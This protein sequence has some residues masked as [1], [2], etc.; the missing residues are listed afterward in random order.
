MAQ[1]ARDPL[2][3][4]L[5]LAI[6]RAARCLV[7]RPSRDAWTRE[8]EAEIRHRWQAMSRRQETEW[9]QQATLVR[10]SSGA[11]ADAA[12][13]RQQ[14]TADLD[15]VRDARYA[16]RMLRARPLVSTFAVVVLAL[17]ICGT[18]TV[19]STVDTLLLRDLPY[20]DSNRIVTI[21]QTP[22]GNPD[23]REGV[24]P[25]AFVDWRARTTS[26]SALGSAE[27]WSFDYLDGPEP[28]ELIGAL[29]TEGFFEA[30]GVQPAR[31]R[32]F[33]PEEYA[34]GRSDVV[35]LSH[36]A[37]Q[38]RFGNDEAMVGRTLRLNGRPHV[39]AGVLPPSFHPDVLRRAKEQEVWAPQTI[40]EFELQN[41]RNRFWAVVGR[42]TPGVSLE[43][44][45][46]ELATISTQ[47]AREYPRTLGGMTATV[48]PLRR[49]LAG[50]VR[51]PLTLLLAAVVMVLL[52]ACANVAS[53][54][55]ARSVE[56]QREFAVRAAIGAARWRLARQTL[57][58]AAVLAA[59]ACAAGLALASLTIRAFVGFTSGLVRQLSDVT[60]DARLVLFAVALTALTTVLVGL[61]P[62]IQ[63]SRGR[64][65]DGLKETSGG[66]TASAH[67]RRFASGLVVAE[68]ALALTLLVGA[69]LLVR[70]F[71]TLGRVDPGFEKSNVAVLQVFAYGPRYATDARRL[72][73]FEQTLGRFRSVP[74]VV[75]A[76]LTSVAPFLPSQIDIQG[77]YRVVGRPAPPDT[78]LPVTTLTV[79]TSDFFHALRIPLRSGRLFTDTDH[80]KAPA[81]A[82]VNDLLAERV[83]PGENPVGQRIEAN[84]QGRWRTMEIVGVVGRVRRRGLESESHPELF[85]PAAQL[86]YGSMT[87]IVQTSGDP[88][89]LMPALKARIWEGDPTL[90]LYDTDTLDSLVAESLAP[91]RFVMTVATAL[92]GLAFVLAALGMYSVLSFSTLQRT[93]EIGVRMAMGGARRHIM[94]MVLRE[95]MRLV[96]A[97]ITLGLAAS[98]L[99]SRAMAALLYNVSPADPLTLAAT[100]GLLATAALL[101]CY[102]P[103]RRAM[104]IDPLQALRAQ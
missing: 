55:L 104:R 89:A 23:D 101:A 9:P 70:S 73:F 46:A 58:E 48:V 47:L 31:G 1:P 11:V 24:A 96:A 53:L 14:F 39:I 7:P 88:A 82:L 98:L 93:R 67:R 5:S 52:I 30:L 40:Q 99:L 2:A 12:W 13:L 75:R 54:M 29:V 18:V 69:G 49:Y 90:P 61:W 22:T 79:A 71:T 64:L 37:W 17:G 95:G 42:L 83:W 78:E 28:T 21:W 26:F 6:L 3:V 103:A 34:E 43:R 91:R 94:T 76:G 86:P 63:L 50:P 59:I 36:G 33:R 56:R 51:E 4:R 100:T 25:G 80:A 65:H 44:A 35:L 16:L 74:G 72:A 68:I 60:L 19:F 8:W 87:F 10:R 15:V 38:R 57:V 92:S 66:L 62:A 77:G 102:L 81:V 85:M 41:R 27:P 97:G 20:A 45:Q 84:W 32:L